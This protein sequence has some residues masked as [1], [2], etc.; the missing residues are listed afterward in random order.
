MKIF[1]KRCKH[2]WDYIGLGTSR[3]LKCPKVRHR[4]MGKEDLQV[5]EDEEAT[6]II[7]TGK[8]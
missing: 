8:K 4:K 3:C 1:R 2:E 7:Y 6:T 5:T